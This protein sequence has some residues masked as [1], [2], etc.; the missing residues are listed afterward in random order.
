M[1]AVASPR[2]CTGASSEAGGSSVVADSRRSRATL[3]A[4][5]PTTSAIASDV[6]P[7]PMVRD[8]V[9]ILQSTS[10]EWTGTRIVRPW[11]C[12]AR[13]IA[14]RSQWPA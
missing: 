14:C 7:G 12:I 3:A 6:A 10:A 9:A 8:A 2:H 1:S 13:V 5:T 4:E 11:S